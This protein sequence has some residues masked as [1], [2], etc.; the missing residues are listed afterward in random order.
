M[1]K[2]NGMHHPSSEHSSRQTAPHFLPAFASASHP[3]L[4]AIG[5]AAMNNESQRMVILT[6]SWGR[7]HEEPLEVLPLDAALGFHRFYVRRRR[8]G[9]VGVFVLQDGREFAPPS[10]VFDCWDGLDCGQ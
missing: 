8:A 10:S 5:R 9:C 6:Y 3:P 2:Y 1:E 4:H 7:L